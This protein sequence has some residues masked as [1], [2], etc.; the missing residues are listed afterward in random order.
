[1]GRC[2]T[3]AKVE[4][5]RNEMLGIV[6]P[7][8]RPTELTDPTD[9][10]SKLSEPETLDNIESLKESEARNYIRTLSLTEMK[11][12]YSWIGEL[13]LSLEQEDF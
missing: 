8:T 4:E 1:M 2:P 6:Q 7:Q 9:T 3:V 10:L 12:L 11:S 5:V 13:I